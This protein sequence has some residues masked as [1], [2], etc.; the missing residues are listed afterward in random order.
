MG[1]SMK[2]LLILFAALFLFISTLHSTDRYKR[3]KVFIAD[4]E[5]LKKVAATGIDVE[6]ATGTLGD[7]V[8]VTMSDKELQKL[9]SMGFQTN[10]SIEDLEQYY[11]QRLVKGSY[12]AL[13]F[14]D[15]SMGGYYTFAEVV[16]QLDSMRTL[17]PNLITTKYS[18]GNTLQGRDIWAVRIAKNAD[19]PSTKPEVLYTALTHAR[20]PEGMMSVIYFMWYLLQNYGTDAE[21]T[22]LVDNRLMYF[23]PVINAD[24]YEAKRRISPTGG[25][26]RRKN[27]RN[28]SADNDAY[29]VDL[30]RNYGYMWGYDDIGSS[31][32]A[33]G[34]TYRGTGSFS[35]PETQTIALFCQFHSFRLALNY[36]SYGMDLLYP[37]DYTTGFESPDSVQ[38]G[39]YGKDMT[40]FN[41]Y[42]YGASGKNLYVVNGGAT[43]WMYGDQSTKNKILALLPEVGSNSDGFWPSS[44]R[45]LPIAQENLYPN[46]YLANVA[47]SYTRFL[48][49]NIV[50]SSGDGFLDRGEPF[51]LN[52]TIR[53]KGIDTTQN[54]SFEITASSSILRIPSGTLPIAPIA[55]FSNQVVALPCSVSTHAPAGYQ[56]LYLK[57]TEEPNRSTY[58]TIKIY[59]GNPDLVFSDSANHGMTNWTTSGTWGLSSTAHSPSYSFTDSPVGNYPDL[60]DYSMTLSSPINLNHS[61]IAL[62]KFWCRWNI[63]SQWDFVTVEASSNG[64]TNWS[65]L[66]GTYT[67]LASGIGV[68]TSGTFGYDGHQNSWVE[69]EMEVSKY[70]SS[71]FK[72][73][74]RLRSDTY[75]NYDG[76]YVDDIRLLVN[77][78]DTTQKTIPVSVYTGWNLVSVPID[79][80][81]IIKNSVFPTSVT[82]AFEYSGGTYVPSDTM[83][84]STGYW[85]KFNTPDVIEWKGMTNSYPTFSV[86]EGWNLIGSTSEPIPVSYIASLPPGI[87]TS[88]FFKY[89]SSYCEADTIYP[90]YGY[91]V[92]AAQIGSLILSMD[93]A[94]LATGIIKIKSTSELPPAP[95]SEKVI[96]KNIPTAFALSDA[97]PNPFNP[98]TVINYQLPVESRVTIK[99]Y[100]VLGQVTAVLSDGIQTAGFKSATWNGA[101]STSG[102]YF[103]QLETV[104]VLDPGKTFTQM[105]KILLLK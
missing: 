30:N 23:V 102:I 95:P 91:W 40:K 74:F 44:A 36:H 66:Q 78:K 2:T 26:M 105:K 67:K 3:V 53:N 73:R 9:N 72:I 98:S 76:F 45:I 77:F 24:G 41:N 19:A 29:G 93:Q 59:I 85:L 21:A 20:E 55:S 56:Y 28:V 103:L 65:S 63:E 22:Y 32:F 71:N 69:E 57:I 99:I 39:E 10:V 58:D 43:D 38:F 6:G 64:G 8:E 46:L 75:T 89:S 33:T 50:D 60:A 96:I 34:E 16:H 84:K 61:D 104:S 25:G 83:R 62:L 1:F 27:M 47:G 15:G 94:N 51:T 17:Y 81:S 82:S 48:Q 11:S 54:L 92:K 88:N 68:Q 100:N 18:I 5:S 80:E 70:A 12:N 97:Y 86:V 90:G 49:S 52:L 87:I 4:K 14:G 42:I 7:W 101:G 37:W 13:G 79:T 31:P 35:E